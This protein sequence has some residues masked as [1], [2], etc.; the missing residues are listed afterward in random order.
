MKNLMKLSFILLIV[1]VVGCRDDDDVNINSDIEGEWFYSSD[2]TQ[3]LNFTQPNMV[4][5]NGNPFSYE[6]TGINEIEL[7]YVGPLFILLP[8]T[9]H[10]VILGDDG[11]SLQF[12]NLESLHWF[13]EEAG[14][15][16][17]ER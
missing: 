13:T 4:S 7:T 12:K 2:R 10:E 16:T 11:S 17:F 8:M 14:D 1:L 3:S 5:V 15:E 9:K 6:V